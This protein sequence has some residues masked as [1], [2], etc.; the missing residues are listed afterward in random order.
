M[1]SYLPAA[2]VS[3]L[4]VGAGCTMSS[5]TPPTPAPRVDVTSFETC[6]AAGNPVM[7]SY[8]RQCRAGGTTYVENV[9]NAVDKTDLIQ[10]T[11]PAPNATVSSPVTVSGQAR[12]TWFFEA[13]FPVRLLDI[14][15]TELGVGIAQAQ[16]DWMT[17]EFVPFTA[18][19]TY[20]AETAG[21]GMLI[22]E[23]DNPSGL[24][25]FADQLELPV[26]YEATK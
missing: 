2:L 21:T 4:F 11:T 25:E 3:L 5:T 18:S 7:E 22:L 20:T 9:G 10:V 19:V 1:R 15:G 12:G 17:E 26:R 24:L 14:N 23:K 6:V 13:S 8:P 16:G